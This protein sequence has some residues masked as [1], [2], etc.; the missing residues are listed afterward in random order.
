MLRAA[1]KAIVGLAGVQPPVLSSAV[2]ETDAIDCE[3]GAGK[4]LNAAL[5]F[6]YEGDP[7]DLWKKLM[8]IESALGRLRDHARNISRKI[9]IDLLYAGEIQID[10][11]ELQL[12]HPR[13]H[14]RRFVLQPLVDIRPDLILPNQTKTVRELLA[15]LD[16]SGKVVRPTNEWEDQ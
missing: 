11:G 7:T 6:D 3:P 10:T 15:E 4:F 12:P 9:D 8:E 14:L 5:E 13:L 2:Y 16:E 1:R